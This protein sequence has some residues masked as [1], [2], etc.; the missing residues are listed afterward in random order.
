MVIPRV[1]HQIWFQGWDQLPWEYTENSEKLEILNQNWSHMKWDEKALRLECEKFGPQALAKFDALDKMIQKVDFGRYI[2]LYNYGGVSV[3]CDAEC[4]R[5][6]D[7]IPG[8]DKYDL[9]LSKNP[10]NMLEN[11][12]TTWGLAKGLILINNATICCSKE[13]PTMKSF[14]QFIIE[15]ESWNDDKGMDTQIKTGPLALSVFFNKFI[16][17][18]LVLDSDIFEPFGNI[19]KRTVLNH[20][21]AQTWTNTGSWPVKLYR[22]IRNNFIIVLIL[23]AVCVIFYIIRWHIIFASKIIRQ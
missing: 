14:I 4:L 18:V 17:D 10:L 6:F 19:N 3:D 8:I 11:K 20:T 7:K 16:D 12:V 9:I 13:N 23:L 21:Y 2:V 15:N 22:I 5:S 1:T